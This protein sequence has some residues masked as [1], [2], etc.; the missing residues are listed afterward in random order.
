MN[1]FLF[2]ADLLEKNE[3][4]QELLVQKTKEAMPASPA[5]TPQR[6][7]ESC[8]F[9]PFLK[10]DGEPIIEDDHQ[11]GMKSIFDS[12]TLCNNRLSGN[13]NRRVPYL[14]RE[15]QEAQEGLCWPGIRLGLGSKAQE[16]L[17]WPVSSHTH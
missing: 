9:T 2:Q 16:G 4:Y 10:P 13:P 1:L 15:E 6:K 11:K 5:S 14:Q 3:A 7:D 17:C 8:T 12:T